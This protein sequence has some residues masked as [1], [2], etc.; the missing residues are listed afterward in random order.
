MSYICPSFSYWYDA[1]AAILAAE[2][3]RGVFRVPM[4]VSLETLNRFLTAIL[5]VNRQAI[6][7]QGQLFE[8][9]QGQLIVIEWDSANAGEYQARLRMGRPEAN[10]KGFN[11]MLV[12]CI[13]GSGLG[14]FFDPDTPYKWLTDEDLALIGA[15]LV[16]EPLIVGQA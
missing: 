16:D 7:I 12:P 5:R 6:C 15:E 8:A 9:N 10:G 13:A 4:P 2:R 3:R 11:G 14:Q 1:E